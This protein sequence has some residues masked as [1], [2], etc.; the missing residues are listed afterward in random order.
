MSDVL[1][2]AA[3]MRGG[4]SAD[5][6]PS[7][8][9]SWKKP[10]D[11][12]KRPLS[13]YNLFFRQE[14]ER[15]MEEHRPPPS[16][17][18]LLDCE[19]TD[20]TSDGAVRDR[21]KR[22]SS[23]KKSKGEKSSRSSSCKSDSQPTIGFVDLARSIATRWNSLDSNA[24]QPYRAMA[25]TE[26][27]Q[28]KKEIARWNRG[29]TKKVSEER[30]LAL[31]QAQIYENVA[32]GRGSLLE[33]AVASMT[34]DP[35]K[36]AAPILVAPQL[37]CNDESSRSMAT[38]P[39]PPPAEHRKK[40]EHTRTKHSKR[41]ALS[42]NIDQTLPVGCAGDGSMKDQRMSVHQQGMHHHVA[43]RV[44]LDGNYKAE[45]GRSRNPT[46]SRNSSK[47]MSV[48]GSRST[49]LDRS[50]STSQDRSRSMSLDRSRSMSLDPPRST[51][52]DLPL[53]D[54]ATLFRQFEGDISEQTL[55]DSN[56]LMLSLDEIFGSLDAQ[57]SQAADVITITTA[58]KEP[59]QND[60]PLYD[61][62][63]EVVDLTEASPVLSSSVPD[64]VL[65]H[66][67]GSLDSE[68]RLAEMNRDVATMENMSSTSHSNLKDDGSEESE[69]SEELVI[70]TDSIT[71]YLS[72]HICRPSGM[73]E[74]SFALSLA[75]MT[76]EMLDD[77]LLLFLEELE[78]EEAAADY[79]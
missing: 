14:R 69:P 72:S 71:S 76:E 50:R 18:N 64:S 17:V 11:K 22:K 8:K 47:D 79:S 51:T 29:Q 27:T 45:R 56:G 66:S 49:S 15:M 62:G 74:C 73:K 68:G 4:E 46:G 33:Y 9:R 26:M 36:K 20:P 42:Q 65:S 77:Q 58:K 75:G 78:S 6:R 34:S 3:C 67:P 21:G 70:P 57:D 37:D 41:S 38:E 61:S 63:I 19:R 24:R 54:D 59:Q 60:Q 30:Q 13:A 7:S 2:N 39:E 25:A 52:L 1:L 44:S 10:K 23:K 55:P 28:Y 43:R 5:A 12:P 40:K 32:A 48:D 31:E 35:K 53:A 16:S